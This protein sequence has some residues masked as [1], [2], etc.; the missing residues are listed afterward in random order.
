[1]VPGVTCVLQYGWTSRTNEFIDYSKHYDLNIDDIIKF[2]KDNDYN[3]D[4]I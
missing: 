2:R 1:M 4:V 3:S